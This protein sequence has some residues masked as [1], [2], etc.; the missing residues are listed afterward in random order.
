M[1]SFYTDLRVFSTN[2]LAAIALTTLLVGILKPL[3]D[4]W[5]K[6]D[7]QLHDSLIRVTAVLCGVA[8]LLLTT[9]ASGVALTA[10]TVALAIINGVVAGL[11]SIGTYHVAVAGTATFRPAPSSAPSPVAPVAV[12]T[13]TTPLDPATDPTPQA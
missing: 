12:V 11:A 4:V 13:A 5:V 6:P 7:A 9:A 2:P 10:Q 1:P 8:L 3:F